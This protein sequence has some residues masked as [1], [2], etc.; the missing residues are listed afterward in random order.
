MILK[1]Y[2]QF[3]LFSHLYFFVVGKHK[4][5]NAKSTYILGK[6]SLIILT[7]EEICQHWR[8]MNLF[9]SISSFTD[10]VFS[11]FRQKQYEF[12]P[13]EKDIKV[14]VPAPTQ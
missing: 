2:L 14:L 8:E 12:K 3:F 4:S 13:S 10:G 5:L 1:V 7:A 6:C 9:S 11:M